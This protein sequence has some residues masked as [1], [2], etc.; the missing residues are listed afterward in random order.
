VV[1]IDA[2]ASPPVVAR[3]HATVVTIPAP[4]VQ[5]VPPLAAVPNAKPA[6]PRP[7]PQPLSYE[8]KPVSSAPQASR[9]PKLRPV[10]VELSNGN[11]VRGMARQVG[12]QIA[13]G[14]VRVVRLTN[15]PT[16]DIARSRVLFREGYRDEAIAVGRQIGRRANIQL[17]N[18]ID[19]R[20]DIRIVLGWDVIAGRSPVATAGEE[21]ET[22]A[23]VD[24]QRPMN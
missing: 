19:R 5:G 21:R 13:V 20:A 18:S 23:Q 15:A 2:P 10:R 8:Q 6:E 1:T 22:I 12:D 9:P 11:G 3:Q 14:T 17:D 16:F 7:E 4:A 24:G